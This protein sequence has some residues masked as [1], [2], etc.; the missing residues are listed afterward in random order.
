MPCCSRKAS[1]DFAV[2]RRQL[3]AQLLVIGGARGGGRRA[4]CVLVQRE[5]AFEQLAQQRRIAAFECNVEQ[6]GR[7]IELHLPHRLQGRE[8]IGRAF[9]LRQITGEL[10]GDLLQQSGTEQPLLFGREQL[11]GTRRRLRQQRHA[12]CRHAGQ[13][14]R[15]AGG[16]FDEQR[17]CTAINRGPEIIEP[18]PEQRR[19]AEHHREH[20]PAT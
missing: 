6:T 10:I 15:L 5:P 13:R 8:R 1:T 7:G 19:D 20:T 14:P 11:R 18:E 9:A 16:C 2:Q 12:V 4:A 3:G 17:R